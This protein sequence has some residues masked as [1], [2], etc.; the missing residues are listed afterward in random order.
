M[1]S[2][3]LRLKVK[4][5]SRLKLGTYTAQHIK[6]RPEKKN[7]RKEPHRKDN[8]KN[9]IKR[10]TKRTAK[11]GSFSAV[12]LAESDVAVGD[13]EARIDS[14]PHRIF[15]CLEWGEQIAAF[16]HAEI[17]RNC[18]QTAA[19]RRGDPAGSFAGPFRGSFPIEKNHPE[20]NQQIGSVYAV[21]FLGSFFRVF[22][23]YLAL[24][25]EKSTK[26]LGI[27]FW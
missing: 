17:Q 27:F 2:D 18:V 23:S 24:C 11:A 13:E 12:L 25:E 14:C 3:S 20:K 1:R 4:T 21:L 26:N 15:C 7:Q 22:F 9:R 10:T 6:K 5:C 8:E 16:K 19:N